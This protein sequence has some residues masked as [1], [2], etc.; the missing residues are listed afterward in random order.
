MTMELLNQ[1]I[2]AINDI[3][4]TMQY[5]KIKIKMTNSR[6]IEPTFAQDIDFEELHKLIPTQPIFKP[7]ALQ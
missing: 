6:V 4:S 5:E 2:K 3:N 7:N 1:L